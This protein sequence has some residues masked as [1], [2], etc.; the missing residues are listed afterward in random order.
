VLTAL[1]PPP[2]PPR[3]LQMLKAIRQDLET[4]ELAVQETPPAE[5]LQALK[6]RASV[7]AYAKFLHRRTEWYAQL[8]EIGVQ[9]EPG[10]QDAERAALERADAAGARPFRLF[11]VV[12]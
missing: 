12:Y 6:F 9:P 5:I 7:G 8:Q 10:R 4:I 3:D 1:I 11:V 2:P